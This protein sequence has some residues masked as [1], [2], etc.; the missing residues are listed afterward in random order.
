[1]IKSL[2]LAKYYQ[3][4][5]SE[6]NKN[7]T[8]NLFKLLKNNILNLHNNGI[9]HGDI[10]SENVLINLETR[11]VGIIDFDACSYRNFNLNLEHCNKYTKKYVQKYG[12]IKEL[13]IFLFNYLT[14]QIINNSVDYSEVNQLILEGYNKHFKENDDYKNICDTILLNAKKPTDKFLIDNYQKVIK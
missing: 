14:Y 13:D 2:T 11:V 6:E 1:M 7:T 8:I 4:Y 5:D 9:I 10:H 3:K 12:V